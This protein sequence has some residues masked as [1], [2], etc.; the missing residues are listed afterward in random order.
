MKQIPSIAEDL[1]AT[2]AFHFVAEIVPLDAVGLANTFWAALARVCHY[3]NSWFK[4]SML[5][6]FSMCNTVRYRAK[7]CVEEITQ[8]L[9]ISTKWN[10]CNHKTRKYFRLI[11]A[12][13]SRGEPISLHL[14]NIESGWQIKAETVSNEDSTLIVISL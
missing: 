14:R 10:I 13:S 6:N 9:T 12:T 4:C 7:P 11:W 8:C 2:P 3:M 1:L 5:S